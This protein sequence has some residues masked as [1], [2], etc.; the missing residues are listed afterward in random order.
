MGAIQAQDYTMSKW[1]VGIRLQSATLRDVEKSLQQGEIVRTHIM[2]PTWHLVPAEDL[3]WMLQLS[4]DRM[5]GAVTI[6]EKNRGIN[7]DL[8]VKTNSLLEK[9]LEGN[10]HLNR[11]EIQEALNRNGLSIDPE[12]MNCILMRAEIDGI[13]CSGIDRGK[14]QTYALLEERIPFSRKLTRDEALVQLARRYFQSH[15]PASVPDFSWWS[16]LS[17][18]EARQAIHSISPELIKDRFSGQNLFVH[19]SCNSTMETDE[20]LYFLPAFDEYLISYKDRTDVLELRH[21]PRA[22]TSNGIFHP[23]LLYQGKVIGNWKK[24]PKKNRITVETAFF[25]GISGIN[26][27]LLNRAEEKYQRFLAL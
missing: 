11:Q 6:Y 26:E 4:S 25:E 27:E 24:V 7:I 20:D 8:H 19:E 13:V 18:T 2:R 15:S 22:F 16:G 12:W 1:A 10:N 21:Q 14:K 9:I 3:R 23:I 5:R 17:L